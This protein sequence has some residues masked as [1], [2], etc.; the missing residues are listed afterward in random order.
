MHIDWAALGVVAV[1]SIAT[2]VIFTILLASG[3][4][5]VSAAKIKSNEGG[6]GTAILSAGYVLLGIAGLL[7]LFGIYL[8][9]PQFH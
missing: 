9:V 5:L 2:S 6:S 8:I 7:V 4:R 1:V 3:I